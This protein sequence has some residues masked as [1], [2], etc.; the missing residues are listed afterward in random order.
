MMKIYGCNVMRS[1]LGDKYRH[2]SYLK[3]DYNSYCFSFQKYFIR[4]KCFSKSRDC[5]ISPNHYEG[6]YKSKK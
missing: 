5:S 6:Y 3:N 1:A 2:C 4:S